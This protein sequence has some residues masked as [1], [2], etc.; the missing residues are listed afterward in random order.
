[1]DL[2]DEM[3]GNSQNHLD[4]RIIRKSL[5]C[6]FGDATSLEHSL[7][8]DKETY[9]AV[10][11]EIQDK[12]AAVL[13]DFQNDG[14]K[15]I[16]IIA[17]SLGCQVISNYIWDAKNY[18]NIF[19]DTGS[20]NLVSKD[21][22]RQNFMKLKSLKCLITT[23]CNIPIFVSGIKEREFEKPNEEFEWFNFYGP[24]DALGWPSKQLGKSYRF[25]K[26][27]PINAGRSLTSWNIFSH[28][29]YWSDEDVIKP[30][31]DLVKK[32]LG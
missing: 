17:Q 21:D 18:I 22:G 23:G 2:W 13:E 5:L 7:H 15:P 30:L 9:L 1:M 32:Y 20:T 26:D 29:K 10:Q 31:A 8:K 4:A 25:V 24:D 28:I 3:I 6:S 14:G 12:L 19:E 11:K 27:R 16:V